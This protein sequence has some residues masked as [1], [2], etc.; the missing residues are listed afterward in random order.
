MWDESTF[1]NLVRLYRSKVY[2]EVKF[3]TKL[4]NYEK[5]KKINAAKTIFKAYFEKYYVYRIQILT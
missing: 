2:G 1:G 5:K 4:I 3:M